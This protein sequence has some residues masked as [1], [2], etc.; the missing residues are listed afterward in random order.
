MSVILPQMIV[1]N[2]RPWPL[3]CRYTVQNVHVLYAACNPFTVL[4]MT[5]IVQ[6]TTQMAAVTR[7]VI[8]RS[9][10]GTVWTVLVTKP[11]SWQKGP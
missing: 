11:R 1:K 10:A 9:V 5:S 4:G 6:I 3:D 7:A 8:V 2:V